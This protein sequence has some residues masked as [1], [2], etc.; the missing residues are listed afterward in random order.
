[1]E[2]LSTFYDECPGANTFKKLLNEKPRN[3]TGRPGEPDALAIIH[4]S[5]VE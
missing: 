1:M 2:V 4:D 3:I 5:L